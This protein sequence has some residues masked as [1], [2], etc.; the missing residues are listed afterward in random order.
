VRLRV[1]A[2]DLTGAL[3]VLAPFADRG[4]SSEV[5]LRS[6]ALATGGGG[7]GAIG[8]DADARDVVAAV[9]ADRLAEAAARL[10]LGAGGL[11]FAKID[12]TL[13]GHPAAVAD[14]ALAASGRTT[15]IVCP[16]VPGQGRRVSGATVVMSDG[17][18]LPMASLVRPGWTIVDAAAD[19]ELD[20]L[21]AAIDEIVDR[22]VVVGAAGLAGALARRVPAAPRGAPLVPPD[23]SLL[24]VGSQ[25]EV[26]A[27][28]VGALKAAGVRC[29]EALGGVVPVEQVGAALA[30]GSVCVVSTPDTVDADAAVAHLADGVAQVVGQAPRPVGL[31]LTGG[32][33]ARAVL[34]ALDLARASVLGSAG[35]GVVALSTG[36]RSLRVVYTKAGGFGG[37]A[38]L[39]AIAKP[40]REPRPPGSGRR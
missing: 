17:R 16:A 28:Q 35:H 39:L 25:G 36:H 21:A 8:I 13:R 23:R 26:A 7:A 3:D 37:A 18:R 15:A 27:G 14:A 30:H 9:G 40:T 10:D 32:A 2:D 24:V 31:A 22:V 1:L 19:H 38:A 20:V 34:L 6:A 29:V 4:V 12:S 33:T 5:V 11:V